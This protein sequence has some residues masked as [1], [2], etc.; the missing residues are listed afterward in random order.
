MVRAFKGGDLSSRLSRIGS[1]EDSWR[2][3]LAWARHGLALLLGA[4]AALLLVLAEPGPLHATPIETGYARVGDLDMYYEVHGDMEAK[5]EPVIVLHGAYMTTGMMRP[6]V[7]GLATGRKVFVVDFQGH[8]RTADIDRPITYQ[9]LA[10]D[11]AAFMKTMGLKRADIVGYSMG[12]GVAYQLAI[13]HPDRV[14]R[15]TAA[16]ASFRKDGL[17]PELLEIFETMTAQSFAG[18]PWEKAYKEVAPD[19]DGF[20]ALVEK[21]VE[22]DSTIEDWPEADMAAIAAPTLVLSGDADIVR[23]EHSV[24]I[25]RLLGGGSIAPH[26]MAAS[27][28]ELAILPGTTHLG[29]MERMDLVVPMVNAFFSKSIP[30]Q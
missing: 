16:A 26:F 12:G 14:R 15:M 23:P 9:A 19:P 1:P 2:A 22:L 30:S 27:V 5:G 18:T 24:R 28:D 8:G 4:V 17:Y 29:V 25:Y 20:E 3:D 11:I 13:R 21:L 6:L 10:D 7:D